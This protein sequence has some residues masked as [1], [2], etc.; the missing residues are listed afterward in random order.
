MKVLVTGANG[1][2]G[3]N[4]VQ[5][6]ASIPNIEVI[7]SDISN[8]NLPKSINFINLDILKEANNPNLFEILGSPDKIIH[9]AWKDG[10]NHF[11]ESHIQELS[12]HFNFLK[13]MINSGV[14]SISVMG[15]AHEIGYYEV[16]VN[17]ETPCNPL[18]YYGMAKNMLRQLLFTYTKDKNISLKWLRAFYITGDDKFNNSVLTKILEAAQKGEKVFPFTDGTNQFDFIEL[19]ELSK[20]VVQ[21]SIQDKVS[22]IINLCSGEPKPIKDVVESFIAD[23]RLD[24]KL[25]YGAFPS[26]RYDSPVIFGNT[27]KIKLILDLNKDNKIK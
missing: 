3:R 21:A 20:M 19:N 27:E 5:L 17:D 14:K 10:F 18:S 13:N 1:Y 23:N 11:A 25:D 7:A 12:Y 4:V 8:S 6:L 15:T 16:E 9:L 22:G 2:I 26:R 24:I